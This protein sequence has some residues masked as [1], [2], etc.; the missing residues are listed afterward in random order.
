MET[1]NREFEQTIER[2]DRLTLS[3]SRRA[4]EC[5]AKLD[6]EGLTDWDLIC[7]CTEVIGLL[8]SVFPFLTED[9]RNI[10]R[11][12][13]MAHYANQEW[14]HA[15]DIRRGSRF[16]GSSQA[17]LETLEEDREEKAP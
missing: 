6:K 13:Y 1:S 16:E 4:A 7:F 12:V 2:I 8:A 3:P 10:N 15:S 11:I 14:S 5:W 17:N 9:A